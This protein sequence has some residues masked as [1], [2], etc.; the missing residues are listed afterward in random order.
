MKE[1]LSEYDNEDN[2]VYDN[3]NS[4]DSQ[5]T[6]LHT[7]CDKN[8]VRV[9][10]SKKEKS[11]ATLIT[12]LDSK[13]KEKKVTQTAR[14]SVN[15]SIC[16]FIVIIYSAISLTILLRALRNLLPCTCAAFMHEIE[17]KRK[18]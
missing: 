3:G 12:K 15:R 13:R 18:K 4:Y 11:R 6:A 2:N 8:R 14:R 5:H 1:F 7:L 9:N 10:S 16:I 17:S